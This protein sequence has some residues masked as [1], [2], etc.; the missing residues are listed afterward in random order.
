MILLLIVLH[1]L[2]E[3]LCSVVNFLAISLIG[4]VSFVVKHLTVKIYY[5]IAT[6]YDVKL[7]CNIEKF[8]KK[9]GCLG[10]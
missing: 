3:N 6:K 10:S 9:I 8:V 7:R 5:N 2:E 1:C 4:L